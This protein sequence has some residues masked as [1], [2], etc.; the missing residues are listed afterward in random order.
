MRQICLDTET[1]G[2]DPAKGDR[3]VEIGCVE[4]AGRAMSDNPK[5]C[6]HVY[7]NP[8]RD[9]PEE[10]VKVHGLDNKFLADK[11]LFAD[12]VEDFLTFIKGAEIIIHNASFDVGFLDS[13]LK[14]VGKKKLKNY[15]G[16]ITDS[17]AMAKRIFPGLHNNLD[18]L[19]DRYSIDRS[20]RTLHGAL[21]DAQ[22][23]GEVYLAMTRKQESL[24][25]ETQEEKKQEEVVLEMPAPDAFILSNIHDTEL[26]AHQDFLGRIMKK[27][28]AL[29]TQ[30]LGETVYGAPVTDEKPK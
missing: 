26:A 12:V 22:L 16:K 23:L 24:L 19:C 7:L 11:P 9:V 10:V 30:E 2:L 1:T 6:F 14:H 20:A 4:I 8:E 27:K 21:L 3:I 13:E 18:K 17:L 28:G 5:Y 15:C 29:W 25:T